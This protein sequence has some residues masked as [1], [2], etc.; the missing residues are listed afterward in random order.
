MVTN[1]KATP[2][3]FISFINNTNEE[4]NFMENKMSNEFK[5]QPTPAAEAVQKKLFIKRLPEWMQSLEQI[6][7]FSGDIIQQWF[8]PAE[9]EIVDGYIGDRGTP[10]ASGKIFIK[11][12][13]EQR[14]D[15]QLSPLYVSR[16]TDTS[17]RSMQFY[18]DLV[19]YMSHYGALAENQSRLFDGKFY[20]WTPPINP[21]KIM[22]FSSYV[23]DNNNEFGLSPDYIVM[24]RGADNG[25]T[26]S[27]QNFWYTVGQTLSDGTVL[28]DEMTQ[29]ARFSH[30]QVPIIEYNKNIELVN[31]GTKFRGVVDYLSDSLQ[32]EDIVQKSLAENIR[33]DG[34]IPQ[35]GDRIL[36]TSIG[37]SGENNRIYNVYIKQMD[38][39]T[40]VYGLALDEDEES[41]ERPTG[42][43]LRGD[44]V[45][46]KS[47]TQYGNTALYWN[48]SIWTPAQAKPAANTAPLFQMYDRN[49]TKLNDP[50]IY[51][52]SSFT[53]SSLFGLKI[54][55]N[56]NFNKIYNA[57]VE[58][59][60]YN[61]YV[62]ENFMQ[63][64]RYEYD[65]VGVRTEIPGLYF[66]NVVGADG[67]M[68]LKSDWDRSEEFS[69]QYVR[70]I[71]PVTKTSM[72]NVFSTVQEMNAFKSPVENM[73]AYVMDIDST[74]KYYKAP[75]STYMDW[76][77]EPSNEAVPSEVF[78]HTY[79]VAQ[80]ID[81]T[82]DSEVFLLEIDGVESTD[83]TFN[84]DMNGRVQSVDI[85]QD[86]QINED[87]IIVI[88]TYSPT[89][90]P[91]FALGSYEIPINLQ[92][93]PYNDFVK[94]IDQS[95]YTPHFNE[96]IARNITSGKV[97]DFNNYEERLE[98]GLVDNTVGTE[99]IQNEASMLPLMIGTANEDIDL[100]ESI[101]FMQSE[102]F[103]F[104]NKFNAQM[105]SMYDADPSA[106]NANSA[107]NIV[108]AIFSIINVGKN[109][110][111]PFYL[112]GMGSSPST[113]RAFVPPTPQFVGMLKAFAPQK[114]TFLYAGRSLGCY[115]VSHTGAITK[116]YK[117][118]NGVTKMDDVIFELESRIFNSIDN[119]FKDVDF[120]PALESNDLFPTPYFGETP[121]NDDEEKHLLLRG[122][123][124]FIATNGIDN[125][126]R[127]YDPNNW[128]TW[129][130]KGTKYVVDGVVSDFVASGSWR[131][132][133][134]D[135]F[136]TYRPAT[137]PWEMLGFAQ[138]PTWWNQEYEPTKI[139]L[140]EDP[141]AVVYVYEALVVDE[142]GDLVPS[143]LWDVNGIQGDASTGTILFGKNAGQ[144][145]KFKRFGT[146]PFTI[147]STGQFT[148]DGEEI[149]SFSLIAPEVLGL[150]SGAL[151]SRAEPW[152]Y[153]DM[154]DME[155]TYRN[156]AMF[157]YDQAMQL[158]RAKPSQFA[159][160]FYDTRGSTLKTVQTG[161][162]Q[163]LFGETN[164]RLNCDS[165]TIVNGEDNTRVLGYQMFV[166]DYL[167]YQNKDITTKY[168][169]V[170]RNSYINVGHKLGGFTK[171]DQ[172]SFYS[173]NS[174]LISQE[175]QHIGLVR[176]SSFR[177]ESMSALEI[178]WTGSGYKISG[179]DLVG[180]VFPYQVPNKNGKKIT[181]KVGNRAV[182]QYMDY[183][184]EVQFIEYGTVMN[185]FQD[186]YSFICSYGE[187]LESRGFIFEDV[188]DEGV[189]QDW[190][191]IAKDFLAW[192]QTAI[193]QGDFIS[194]T[195]SAKSV[196][197]GSDFGSVQA[198]AQFN[199]GVWTLLDDNNTGIRP[200]EIETA[201]I[202]NVLTVRSTQEANKRI[203]LI[204]LSLVA[205]EHAI[206]FD[207]KTIFGDNIYIPTYGSIQELIRMY[208]YITGG[209]TG[210]LEAPGFIILEAGTIPDFEKLVDD[211]T[212]YYDTEDPVS[213]V[214][215]RALARHLIGY[216]TR[217]YLNNMITSEPSRVDFYKG[218]IRDKGTNQ[219]LERVLRV[220]KSY[221]T[222]GYKAL[223][224]WAFKIGEYGNVN[225]K[226]NLQFNLLNDQFKQQPQLVQFDQ[227]ATSD[228]KENE[229]VYFGTIGEDPRWIT[230][231]HGDFA[232]PM[233]S[234]RSENI[235][236]PNIGPVTL[237]EVSYVTRDLTTT[238][239]DRLVYTANTGKLPESVWVLKDVDGN[240]NIY[241]I[242][243][244]S[245]RLESI[246]P[247]ITEDQY[248]A[249]KVKL[250][251]NG[252]SGLA[253]NDTYFFVD[254]SNYM[255]D[256]LRV[257]APY[258]NTGDDSVIIVSLE[259]SITIDFSGVE[260]VMY[261][262][263]PR[264]STPEQKQAYID[265]KYEYPAVESTLFDRPSTYNSMTNVIELYLNTYDPINGVLPGTAMIDVKY[266]ST[267][268][269]ATYNSDGE[270][271]LAW[272]S[273]KVGE[274]WWDTSEAF[275]MDY[276]RPLYDSNGNVDEGKTIEYKRYN[277][278]KMLPQGSIN[279]YEWVKSPVEPYNWD[280]YCSEQQKKNK[281]QN[282]N[283]PSGTAVTETYSYF[284]EYDASTNTY[285]PYFYFWVKDTIY[286]PN[287]K[288]RTKSCNEI[289]R[290]IRDPSVLG[291]PWFSPID[292][293]SFILS[294]MQHDINDDKSVLT[295]SYKED[296]DEV[297]K[298]EQ[299]QLCKEGDDYNF[300]SDI[301]S[302][303]WNSLEC[304]ETL[305]DG[306]IRELSY[307]STELGLG[308][309][310]TWFMNPIEARRNMVSSANLIYKGIN[311]TTNT[312]V[313]NEVFNVKTQATNPNEVGFKVLTYNNELVI[314]TNENKFVE[315]DAVLVNTNGVLPTPLN[316][317][318]V[319][320]V[321]F[322]ENDYIR[323]MNSPST[324]GN[325]VVI[326]LENRGE[327]QHTM[328]KQSDYIDALGT[329]LD[330]TT[331]WDL[332]DWYDEGFDEYSEYT[333]ESS[334]QNAN[335][336][337]YQVGD[338]I[339]ITDADGTWTLYEKTLSRGVV[340]WVAVG[341]QNS[342]I[343][344]NNT[345]YNGYTQY[346]STG[347]LTNTEKNVRSALDLL[348]N[349]FDGQ[350]SN[351]VFDM[352]KYAHTE[353]K[354]VDWVF[355]TS[356]IYIIG[357][358]QSLESNYDNDSNLIGDI[359]QYFEEVKPYR[360]KIR[361]QIEQKTSDEDEINGLLND[362]DPTGYIHVDGAWVKTQ[363]DIWDYERAEFNPVTQKWEIVGE[364]PTG[365]VTPQRRFQEI[366]VILDFDNIQCKPSKNLK[367]RLVLENVNSKY[368][369]QDQD[370]LVA[371]SHYK[372]QR[373]SYTTPVEP[374]IDNNAEMIVRIS[375]E[376]P[377][378]NAGSGITD[379]L[380]LL[381]AEFMD[382]VVATEE[383]DEFIKVTSAEVFANDAT[384]QEIQDYVDFNT[385]ANRLKLYTTK[386]DSDISTEVDCPFK[387]LVL[388][389][390][391]NTRLPFGFSASTDYN[392]GYV[393][394]S[395]DM[396]NKILELA[397]VAQPTLSDLELYAYVEEEYGL[398]PWRLDNDDNGRFYSDAVHV[399]AAMRGI[400]NPD[401]ADPLSAA[402]AILNNSDVDS[403]AMVMVPRKFVYLLSQ[404]T[405]GVDYSIPIDK[406]IEEYMEDLFITDN[407]MVVL[408]Q[409]TL[410]DLPEDDNNPLYSDYQ[411]ILV[412]LNDAKYF[413]DM[414]AFDNL[415][416]ESQTKFI[417]SDVT[418]LA[419]S[420]IDPVFVDIS[421][422]NPSK[423]DMAQLRFTV[424]G[425]GFDTV[426][427][428][429]LRDQGRYHVEGYIVQNPYNR[430]EAL[431]SIPRYDVALEH[432]NRD[433]LIKSDI[434]YTYRIKSIT[435]LTG[436]V[437][438]EGTNDFVV[439]ETVAVFVP[440]AEDYAIAKADGTWTDILQVANIKEDN[441]PKLFTVTN[442]QGQSITI[443]GL[444]FSSTY[445]GTDVEWFDRDSSTSINVVRV[446]SFTDAEF[447]TGG[448]Q[449]YTNN[450]S[451]RVDALDYDV[452]YDTSLIG[453]TYTDGLVPDNYDEWYCTNEMQTL[454][455]GTIID[456]GYYM[457]VYGKGVLSELVRAKM[458]DSLEIFVYEYD[459]AEIGPEKNGPDGW[460]YSKPMVDDT[461]ISTD[462]TVTVLFKSF[463]NFT[464]VSTPKSADDATILNGTVSMNGIAFD[465]VISIRAEQVLVRTND[466][467]LRG[468][469]GTAE[470]YYAKDQSYTF[471]SLNLGSGDNIVE[472]GSGYEL[473]P[474]TSYTGSLVVDGVTV[475]KLLN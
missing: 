10:A 363:K 7:T 174:G 281:G 52:N 94:Y 373:F 143:G 121:Y 418:G 218:F 72:Y 318:S 415:A 63:S 365:F 376:Y 15:Y 85:S 168:G 76:H 129:N 261:R 27:L 185:S 101:M 110:S 460:L 219:V 279:V 224:E 255:P 372:L 336:K 95:L 104:V 201:R 126:T 383:L 112:D 233:R 430:S 194:C 176:S 259:T 78:E 221:N 286:T 193:S 60:S 352:V 100:F 182:V 458:T 222:E 91:D 228:T 385:L 289:A 353:Q 400:V 164:K 374:D 439:G 96:I 24:E 189:T 32:P 38:D 404:T 69:K 402:R 190:T 361:S 342:T 183:T 471:T 187:Y 226:K 148:T 140:A 349:S 87:T 325:A 154:G 438:L 326:T 468:Y 33:I 144:Y 366:D 23:W 377:Q 79:E 304:Q 198:V 6:Q 105:I 161:L 428:D 244:T 291:V 136:G 35:A 319:Y 205:F 380:N 431:V 294:N 270:T 203:A 159:N 446:T 65:K 153:G 382:D 150:V 296:H 405:P 167:T 31:Y 475:G 375:A 347:Q 327:G 12:R 246:E 341:R 83:Y 282:K 463:D 440:N 103:R 213:D 192:S 321:H 125:G 258:F 340:Q 435:G 30:A 333:E 324:S 57:N 180:A 138:R 214:Q 132:L 75:N 68:H 111:F 39:G 457:P 314:S 25:N 106:F 17:V 414:N 469:N 452:F 360:T 202:G 156:T 210:R 424:E 206:I 416:L 265:N 71:P 45:L 155:F 245:V 247:I 157:C 130:Y 410:D 379:G 240:W 62:F 320:F 124:N 260:P 43:P 262:Y 322:D 337:N 177:D 232:F 152:A 149:R 462:C 371:G 212:H 216:Q 301:W 266:I 123:I 356:Y 395:I 142:N 392:Y 44:V 199:G 146:Q 378:F 46:I 181:Q 328:I 425:Y 272:G 66:Y 420:T 274:V 308:A 278:G 55:F 64:V 339:R 442:V 433:I 53:G 5:F 70:Q 54:N 119:A 403:Y 28:T 51:A 332:A 225:G 273:D 470:Y 354:V 19:G 74:F 436:V 437:T 263:V 158:Y 288:N 447:S 169:D 364:L 350:Q 267:R 297:V 303:L 421:E 411:Q 311:M 389:D 171:E 2:V 394:Y 277:W 408:S 309:S 108:D 231:P 139:R 128:M 204:R 257:E 41:Q 254:E 330:M 351:I 396:Y 284:V 116:A 163:F 3:A 398:Y 107:T 36:F 368:Q 61:Y 409:P 166:S 313:M 118:L 13:T 188:N 81:P 450:R 172:L 384:I 329:S 26:W 217:E 22:N 42:E 316:R 117:V 49:G 151:N 250:V 338:L 306:T 16:N 195:P 242:V 88:K 401:D 443:S 474:E 109:S 84:L 412:G 290:I 98:A 113:I 432:M 459:V 355:K 165:T 287:T 269:P 473:I 86:V 133:Y 465:D 317:T 97:D 393:N 397:R 4:M 367:D 211:F 18:E 295:I 248:A 191:Q 335:T 229:I 184:R 359:V 77:L 413:D 135:M 230:R 34:F 345:W 456:N 252:N 369:S 448:I 145:D 312:V 388:S 292:S 298:H 207:D 141:T 215:L 300:N 80:R 89:V 243:A 249:Q 464:Y 426:V 1:I 82:N 271:L 331:Y 37:N 223:Q 175:N 120:V 358:D 283:M 236:L 20:S 451:Y 58:L 466:S 256:L 407:D 386:S 93:N 387:G 315:N 235:N 310:K 209:W 197:F 293:D 370:F 134:S 472:Y 227:N 268:D 14:Q 92:N 362:L 307:P 99:I 200:N 253:N 21:N 90:I 239:A 454:S 67:E 170:L 419:S 11:E 56:Y 122:Y 449:K 429:Q 208:G 238:Y 275:F 444:I 59:S 381:Y 390:N 276:T 114:A 422:L 285:V 160:Y 357:L 241:D 264:F 147:E 417:V 251:L 131:A 406:S 50:Q 220:S 455:D 423:R 179:Y 127:D 137:H 234:G 461:Y 453:G 162:P 323:L 334:I 237:D 9:Q 305:N 102:Y 467:I 299:Y 173:E 343:Q 344:L 434:N 280:Q 186:V 346:D 399:L 40:R 348:K 445:D 441:R 196:K 427:S 48:G 178:T 8:N 391:S 73:Y 47:G 29:D 302:S 115:N